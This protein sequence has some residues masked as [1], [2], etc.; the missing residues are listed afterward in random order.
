LAGPTKGD[1]LRWIQD[2]LLAGRYTAT[3]HYLVERRDLRQIDMDDIHSAVARATSLVPYAVHP[4]RH[5]GTCW[6]VMGPDADGTRTIGVGVEAYTDRRRRR[7][8]IVTVME[9]TK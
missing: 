2:A 6:R 4:P 1:A 7:V 9:M 5:G 8:I 3:F